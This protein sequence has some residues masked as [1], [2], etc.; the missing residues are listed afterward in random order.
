VTEPALPANGTCGFPGDPR[1]SKV[2][3]VT[4]NQPIAYA[5]MDVPNNNLVFVIDGFRTD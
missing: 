1:A 4:S 3:S 2:V 5:I